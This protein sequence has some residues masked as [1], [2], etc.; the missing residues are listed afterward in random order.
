[1]GHA[2]LNKKKD[3]LGEKYSDKHGLLQKNNDQVLRHLKN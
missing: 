3:L 2:R 1:V